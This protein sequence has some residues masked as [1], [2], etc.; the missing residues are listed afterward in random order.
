MAIQLNVL[1]PSSSLTKLWLGNH[2]DLIHT[3]M[4]TGMNCKLQAN[5]HAWKTKRMA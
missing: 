3:G 5:N 1:P 4:S 2:Y